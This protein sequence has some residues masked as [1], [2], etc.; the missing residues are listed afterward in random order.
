M[1][2]F[3]GKYYTENPTHAQT[4]CTMNFLSSPLKEPGCKTKI[5]DIVFSEEIAVTY[6]TIQLFF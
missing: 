4:V 2:D 6:N 5:T 1:D 3:T